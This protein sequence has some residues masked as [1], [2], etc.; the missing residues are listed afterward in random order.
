MGRQAASFDFADSPRDTLVWVP[1]L[2][3]LGILAGL[4]LA[5]VAWLPA[6]SGTP[7]GTGEPAGI[8]TPAGAG[9]PAATGTP[10]S[11]GVRGSTGPSP[12]GPTTASPSPPVSPTPGSPTRSA[13]SNAPR[14]APPADVTGRYRVVA[15]F[16]T[17]FTGEVLIS[18][19]SSGPRHWTVRLE[20]D[21]DVGTIRASWVEAQPPP[22]LRR[23][24]SAYIFTSTAPVATRSA[25]MLRFQFERSGRDNTPESCST[26][27]LTCAGLG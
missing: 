5:V 27:G 14:R 3:G 13:V 4:L 1:A 17:E 24:G 10:A 11:T 22:T 21:S 23:S 25:V 8:G 19:G 12:T 26:N 18:N 7:A 15:S 9:T 2:V 16:R 20:F 6:D